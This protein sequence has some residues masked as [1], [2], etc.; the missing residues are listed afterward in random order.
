[1]VTSSVFLS[2][3][4]TALPSAECNHMSLHAWLPKKLNA[5][6][7][8]WVWRK[9]EV[10]TYRKIWGE[11]EQEEMHIWVDILL[12]LLVWLAAQ[13]MS[14]FFT[15]CPDDSRTMMA[16]CPIFVN[17]SFRSI[18]FDWKMS[19][20]TTFNWGPP[21]KRFPHNTPTLFSTNKSFDLFGIP[22]KKLNVHAY[23]CL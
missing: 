7:T 1:M 11:L 2:A 23:A 19:L 4:L 13:F 10:C 6:S 5:S 22:N 8:M 9:M 14:P 17:Y 21:K 3:C 20:M 16:C 12:T 18:Q 15:L